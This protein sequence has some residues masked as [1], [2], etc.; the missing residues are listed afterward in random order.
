MI[1]DLVDSGARILYHL[2]P[3]CDF[4][5]QVLGELI[6]RSAYRFDTGLDEAIARF[7]L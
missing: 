6:C 1:R 3:F 4:R 5:S 2:R 7:R